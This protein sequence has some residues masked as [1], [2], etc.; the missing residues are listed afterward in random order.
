MDNRKYTW[1][2]DALDRKAIILMSDLRTWVAS[3]PAGVYAG[4]VV[5]ILKDQDT[6]ETESKH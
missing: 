5:D 4:E 6:E 1:G 3:V 2:I